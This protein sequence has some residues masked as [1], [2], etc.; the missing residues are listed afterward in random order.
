MSFVDDDCKMF[1]F[2]QKRNAFYRIPIFLSL[3]TNWSAVPIVHIHRQ[4][5][6]VLHS[7]LDELHGGEV[8]DGLELHGGGVLDVDCGVGANRT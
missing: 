6:M 1:N 8:G 3:K 2:K 7:F 4:S 5:S